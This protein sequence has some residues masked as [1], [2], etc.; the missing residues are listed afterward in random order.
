MEKWNQNISR[1]RKKTEYLAAW[2]SNLEKPIQLLY[3]QWTYVIAEKSH[4]NDQCEFIL[5][6][7]PY[8]RCILYDQLLV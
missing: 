5:E 4:D 1:R 3:H 7:I 2:F 6:S 8:G